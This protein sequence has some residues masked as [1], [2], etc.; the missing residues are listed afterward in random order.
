MAPGTLYINGRFLTQPLTGVQ[1]YARELTCAI[2]EEKTPVRI[3]VPS[4]TEDPELC[5]YLEPVGR[6]QGHAWEQIDLPHAL[7]QRGTPLLLNLANL[8]PVNYTRQVLTLHDIAFLRFPHSFSWRFRAFYRAMIPVLLRRVR[9]VTTVSEF[10][11]QEIRRSY[12]RLLARDDP[13]VIYNA[14]DGSFGVSSTPL[15]LRKPFLLAVSSLTSQKNFGRLLAAFIDSVHEHD[16]DLVVVGGAGPAFQEVQYKT[17]A[18]HARVHMVGR[19][20]DA[21]LVALYRQA[22]AF[23]FP[24]L[25]EGFGLPPLEA[26]ACGCPVAASNIPATREILGESAVYFDPTNI[27]AIRQCM[28]R[29]VSNA[30]LRARLSDAGLRNVGRF[31]WRKSAQQM[32]S[33]LNTL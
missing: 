5:E 8:A 23:V 2:I 17:E 20:E 31:D 12:P 27:Q 10:S 11:A 25:Y 18:A 6:L 19:V 22:S 26:Q 4:H 28:L 1:R 32:V 14:V 29:V 21:E 33:L 30:E 7:R 15:E 3:L 16:H 24:S 9:R 13:A